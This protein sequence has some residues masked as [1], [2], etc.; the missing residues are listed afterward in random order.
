[1]QVGDRPAGRT[2]RTDVTA[3]CRPARRARQRPLAMIEMRPAGAVCSALPHTVSQDLH[4]NHDSKQPRSRQGDRLVAGSVCV[5]RRL[6]LSRLVSSRC[7]CCCSAPHLR[8]APALQW[9]TFFFCVVGFQ[10]IFRWLL[11]L[12]LMLSAPSVT[13][14]RPDGRRSATQP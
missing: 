1:V 2:E 13:G 7:C 3:W 10:K 6:A 9:L 11:A 14:W 8:H 4:A 5:L 12:S